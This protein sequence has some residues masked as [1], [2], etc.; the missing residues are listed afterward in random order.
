MLFWNKEFNWKLQKQRLEMVRQANKKSKRNL[1]G[2]LKTKWAN[3]GVN[4]NGEKRNKQHMT[5][6][7]N[8][9]QNARPKSNV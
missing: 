9:W 6:T 4:R 8:K 1:N 7:G 3:T 2:I 5:H